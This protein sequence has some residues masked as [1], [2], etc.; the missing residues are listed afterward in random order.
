MLPVDRV[1]AVL[2]VDR[3]RAV[4]PVD[5]VRALLLHVYGFKPPIRPEKLVFCVFKNF[6]TLFL[7]VLRPCCV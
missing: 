6:K 2:P 5:R 4:L 1:R 7:N 3:V